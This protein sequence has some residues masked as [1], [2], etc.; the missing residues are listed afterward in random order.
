MYVQT[1]VLVEFL[2]VTQNVVKFYFR[3]SRKVCDENRKLKKPLALDVNQD[4]W[5]E[6]VKHL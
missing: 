3:S 1:P 4:V 2:N 5:K 6:H